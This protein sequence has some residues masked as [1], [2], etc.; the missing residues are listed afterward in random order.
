MKNKILLILSVFITFTFAINNNNINYQKDLKYKNMI[1]NY[2]YKINIPKNKLKNPFYKT[3]EQK[4]IEITTNKKKKVKKYIKINILS[5]LDNNVYIKYT[6]FKGNTVN[7]MKLWV[8]PGEHF[9]VCI[10]N[11]LKGRLAIFNCSG[12]IIKKT[13]QTKI[14]IKFD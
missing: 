14:N 3:I 12:K 4:E 8:K 10:Y 1:L 5:I 6:E 7:S 13:L 2:V 9:G 11:K